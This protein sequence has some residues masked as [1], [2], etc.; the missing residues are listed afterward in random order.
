[1]SPGAP[2]RAQ[3]V[4]TSF[5]LGMGIGTLFAG[6][7]SDR[8]GRRRVLLA[9]LLYTSF[10]RKAVEAVGGNARGGPGPPAGVFRKVQMQGRCAWLR[11]SCAGGGASRRHEFRALPCPQMCIRDSRRTVQL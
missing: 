3:L 1:M 10:W 7:L 4:V 6:P 8:F 11:L 2:N 9:C 5:V